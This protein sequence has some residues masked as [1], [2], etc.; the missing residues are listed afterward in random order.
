MSTHVFNSHLDS[1]PDLPLPIP[2][3]QGS[4]DDDDIYSNPRFDDVESRRSTN[5]P[6]NT[7]NDLGEYVA[8]CADSTDVSPPQPGSAAQMVIG[9]SGSSRGIKTDK[10]VTLPKP[11]KTRSEGR[12][13]ALF[14]LL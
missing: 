11:T 7:N 10:P 2:H 12:K 13:L 14:D 9:V 3:E 5:M 6:S 8:M 1:R 4:D